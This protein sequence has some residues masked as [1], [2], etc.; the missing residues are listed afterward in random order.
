[1]ESMAFLVNLGK[2][3]TLVDVGGLPGKPLLWIKFN[4][5]GCGCRCNFK[6]NLFE[7]FDQIDGKEAKEDIHSF[8][9]LFLLG[10]QYS[11]NFCSQCGRKLPKL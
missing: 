2:R 11:V 4:M 7:D 10:D 6:A 3:T 8:M 1:M 5:P 9:K